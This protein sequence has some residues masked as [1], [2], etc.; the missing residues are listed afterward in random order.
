MLG[1]TIT[2]DDGQPNQ[3]S[4]VVISY[5]FWQRRLGGDAKVIGRHLNIDRV[6]RAVIGVM[7]PGFQ[8][9]IKK[10]SLT[11]KSADVWLPFAINNEMRARHG[12]F[13]TVVGRLKPG[14]PMTQAQAE[15]RTIGSRLE[16]QYHD[17]NANWGINVVPL[18][19]QLTGE[20]RPALY[21]LLGAV[22]FVL[23]IACANV[24]N[25]LL[26][27]AAAR[28]KEMAI[29]TALGARRWRVVRQLLTEG[30]PLAFLGGTLGLLLAWW[31]TT[32]LVS[33]SPAELIDLSHVKINLPVLA[34]TLGV[35]V[36][37]GMIFQPGTGIR[38]FP[39]QPQ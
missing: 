24:A 11:A 15:M 5:G 20:I 4:V 34:F 30:I 36:L 35:S 22:S 31:G 27:R 29:R 28:Q 16:Q 21:V 26:A 10:G 33:L 6:D 13:M 3:P 25:L 9:F 23:L 17:F 12:R 18:R 2:P 38:I 14:I 1:R 19:T 32:L 39:A 37:T 8:W 7:P